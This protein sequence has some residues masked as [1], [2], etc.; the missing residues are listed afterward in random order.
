MPS[1]YCYLSSPAP[2]W[3]FADLGSTP[4]RQYVDF[5]PS[6]E[7]KPFN[8]GNDEEN[9]KD[10]MDD[11]EEEEE[12]EE[13]EAGPVQPS[14]PPVVMGDTASRSRSREGS[15]SGEG[16]SQE[17]SPA[18]PT[19]PS[20]RRFNTAEEVAVKKQLPTQLEGDDKDEEGIDLMK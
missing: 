14:S 3:K 20:S 1:Q 5:S 13:V 6:K 15:N 19:R 16:D 4:A 11:D 9:E 12:E 18:T 17:L 8:F 7:S 2:F 10:E